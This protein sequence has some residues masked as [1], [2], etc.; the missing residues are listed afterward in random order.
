M[1]EDGTNDDENSSSQH[2]INDSSERQQQ[3]QPQ[4]HLSAHW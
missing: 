2:S 4:T 3:F 1:N